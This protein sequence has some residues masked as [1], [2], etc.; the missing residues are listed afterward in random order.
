MSVTAVTSGAEVTNLLRGTGLTSYQTRLSETQADD[1][2]QAQ[3]QQ[4]AAISAS[5]IN[6]DA[7]RQALVAQID[8][9]V[10]DGKLSQE[11]ATQVKQALGLADTENASEDS[12]A[13]DEDSGGLVTH[14][15]T[16][17]AGH[18][19]G[20]AGGGSESE[21]SEISRTESIA[22]GVKTTVILYDDG[23]TETQ[24]TY[25]TTPDTP[26]VPLVASAYGKEDAESYLL[27]IAHGTF[28]DLRA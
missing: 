16:Q 6:A 15:T 4:T 21:P 23:T 24:V 3:L 11:D 17:A 9:D 8:S 5:A 25:T 12:A 19:G 10:A 28:L 14:S 22:N 7:L 26:Q 18:A 20:G 2:Q 13:S 1:L 27:N